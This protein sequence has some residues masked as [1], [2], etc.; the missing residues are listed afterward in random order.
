MQ[1]SPGSDLGAEA[2]QVGWERQD[3]VSEEEGGEVW[4]VGRASPRSPPSPSCGPLCG[5]DMS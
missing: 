3:T 5:R 4:R 2:G 1:Q